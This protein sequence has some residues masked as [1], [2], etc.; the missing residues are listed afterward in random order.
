MSIIASSIAVAQGGDRLVSVL[1]KLRRLK[2]APEEVDFLVAEASQAKVAL[3]SLQTTV[4][5]IAQSGKVLVDLEPLH[6]HLHHYAAL[7]D[8][9]EGLINRY[10]MRATRSEQCELE[11]VALRWGW[12][13][14]KSKVAA[15][16]DKIRDQWLVI[17]GEL[18]SISS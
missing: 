17:L 11:L 13:P 1:S 9:L 2:E 12:A 6:S 14:K 15:L 8:S 5:S 16:R 7:L 18:A 3:E 10:L 4:L